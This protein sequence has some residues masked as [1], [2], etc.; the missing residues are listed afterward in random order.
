MMCQRKRARNAA[1]AMPRTYTA[2]RVSRLSAR[3]SFIGSPALGSFV[4]VGRALVGKRHFLLEG[5]R[6][7]AETNETEPPRALEVGHDGG[8]Q[9]SVAI[10]GRQGRVALDDETVE[11]QGGR[12]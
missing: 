6:V 4:F 9:G 7:A 2:P 8:V 5:D 12:R 10:V 3:R 11:V 1:I